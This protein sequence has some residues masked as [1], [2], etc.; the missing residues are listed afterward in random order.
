MRRVGLLVLSALAALPALSTGPARAQSSPP[1]QVAAR[2]ALASALAAAAASDYAAAEKALLAIAR[3]H[4]DA[5]DDVPALTFLREI[6]ERFPR[7]PYTPS[8]LLEMA[9]RWLALRRVELTVYNG[10][11]H[12][13]HE[14]ITDPSMAAGALA[15]SR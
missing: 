14:V 3:A 7:G 11:P 13:K 12:L 10:I 8:A 5:K 1:M 2:G 6:V 9:D 15:I 4:R